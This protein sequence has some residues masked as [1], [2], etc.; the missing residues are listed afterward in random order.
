MMYKLTQSATRPTLATIDLNAFKRN[1]RTLKEHAQSDYFLAV[2]KT[3]AYGHGI[4]PIAQAALEAGADWLGITTLEEGIKLR[5]NGIEAPLLLLSDSFTGQVPDIVAYDLTASIS[6]SLLA[7]KLS[8]EA[9]K[10]NSLVH[11]HLKVDTGLY[12]FGIPPNEALTF[13]NECYDLPGLYWEGIFSHF[14]DTDDEHWE[15]TERQFSL[16]KDTVGHLEEHGF[17]F[18]IKHVGGST[19]TIERS[20][21]HLNMVRPGIALFGYHP[22]PSQKSLLTL[23]PVM[24]LATNI[25][26]LKDVPAGTPVGYSGNYV[27]KRDEKLAILP[28]GL[29]DG[30]SRALSN[31]GYVLVSG[32]KANIVGNISLDQTVIDVT[33]IPHVKAG[34]VV[35]VIGKMG[36]EE[37]TAE[38]IAGWMGSIVDEVLACL[39]DRVPR[40]YA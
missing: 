17:N 31:N 11:I 27:T 25:L 2:V 38:E 37:I 1:L 18:P 36:D 22:S 20:D 4:V 21:M 40:V 34:D 12:R 9:I 26:S 16:F 28:I 7:R 14:S 24:Q 39:T 33:H 29:G 35:V 3:N 5:E 8:S 10:Q 32:K 30:F 23:T 6:S 13:C 19:I 15:K